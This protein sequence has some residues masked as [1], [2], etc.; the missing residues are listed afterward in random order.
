MTPNDLREGARLLL[1]LDPRTAGS[2]LERLCRRA[3]W[4]PWDGSPNNIYAMFDCLK[5][6]VDLA[7]SMEKAAPVAWYRHN[8]EDGE[9]EAIGGPENPNIKGLDDGWLPAYPHPPAPGATG[10]VE[11]K[12]CPDCNGTK[13]RSYRQAS[14]LGG[15][16]VDLPCYCTMKPT[17]SPA[18]GEFRALLDRAMALNSTDAMTGQRVGSAAEI[19]AAKAAVLNA[20]AAR[21]KDGWQPIETAPMD[22]QWVLAW[23]PITGYGMTFWNN[24]KWY[25]YN[26]DDRPTHWMPLPAKPDAV[27]AMEPKR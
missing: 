18:E 16:Y 2:D 25:A 23:H 14:H 26:D 4:I 9:W 21:A 27:R 17:P 12:V 19:T 15:Q 22:A 8:D 3:R 11:N 20:Y 5:A 10:A 24:V 6:F 7:D 1:E 13:I